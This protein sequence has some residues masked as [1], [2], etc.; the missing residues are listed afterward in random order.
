MTKQPVTPLALGLFFALATLITFVVGL[1]FLFPDAPLDIIWRLKPQDHGWLKSHGAL[2]PAGF[3][4]L[5]AIMAAASL[6]C[7]T[8]QRWG[9]VLAVLIFI[10]NGIVDAAR[11]AFDA[12]LEGTVGATVSAIVIWWLIQPRVRRLFASSASLGPRPRRG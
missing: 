10:A 8:R 2:V 9:W 3:L 7:L 5:S 11:I 1:S 4:L 6:G 12:P